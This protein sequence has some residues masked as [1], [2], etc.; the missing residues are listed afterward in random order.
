MNKMPS[1]KSITS[2]AL[3]TAIAAALSAAPIASAGESPFA[4]QSIGKG[5]MVAEYHEGSKKEG[6]GEKKSGEGRCGMSMA[7]TD[8][9]G[10]VSKE[11]HA[12]HSQLMFEKMD[13]NGDGYIDKDEA[14]KMRMKYKRSHSQGSGQGYGN[15]GQAPLAGEYAAGWGGKNLQHMKPMGE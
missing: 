15:P 8:K 7:D 2:L 3:G 9:D 13:A 14:D 1:K 12:R 5:Y 4:V 10:R 11:E 6:Y